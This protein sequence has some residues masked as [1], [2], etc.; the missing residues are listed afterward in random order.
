MYDTFMTFHL[1]NLCKIIYIFVNTNK[2]FLIRSHKIVNILII[3]KLK[4]SKTLISKLLSHYQFTTPKHIYNAKLTP[5]TRPQYKP[6]G[7]KWEVVMPTI[8]LFLYLFAKYLLIFCWGGFKTPN[9]A[10]SVENNEGVCFFVKDY[11]FDPIFTVVYGVYLF[12]FDV[13]LV[14]IEYYFSIYLRRY[15]L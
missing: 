2:A 6:S 10:I 4:F 7:F 14:F 15:L 1:R 13:F 12:V 3:Y 11:F 8:I 9:I 5:S